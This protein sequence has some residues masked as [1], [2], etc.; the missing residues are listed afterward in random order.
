[1][2]VEEPL[3]FAQEM[4]LVFLGAVVT[5]A[6]TAALLNRRPNRASEGESDNPSAAV[7]RVYMSCIEKVAEIVE[8]VVADAAMIDDLK[9]SQSQAGHSG[10]QRNCVGFEVVLEALLSVSRTAR[11][12]RVTA[13]RIDAI[14]R[15][16]NDGDAV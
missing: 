10:Q 1:M 9:N 2:F 16:S 15:R 12:Q 14:R 7:R 11:C 3:P 8:N 5:I 4:T 6:L 13:R